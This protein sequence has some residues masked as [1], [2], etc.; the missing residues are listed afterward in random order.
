MTLLLSFPAEAKLF[1]WSSQADHSSADPHGQ[2]QLVNNAIN[3]Q[4]YETLVARG[5][6]MEIVP[7]LAERWTQA[8]ATKWTFHLRKGVKWQDGS[9][10]TADDVVFS[11]KRAQGQTSTFKVY[12][13]ALGEPRKVDAHT[14]EFTTVEPTPM[15]VEL[16]SLVAIMSKA[17]SEKHGVT[18]AQDFG[19][20][21]ET[22]ASRN[23]MGTGPFVLVSREPDVKSVFRRNPAWWGM[24][25]GLFEGNVEE[26]VYSTIKSDATRMAALASGEVDFVLDPPIQDIQKLKADKRI[27]VYEGP[28][29]LVFFLG[30]DQAREELLHADVRGR[31]PFKDRRVRLALYQAIDVEA[32]NRVVLR[33][34]AESTAI[35]HPNPEVGGIPKTLEKRYPYDLQAARKLMADAGYAKGF[36]ITMD[37]QNVRDKL[38]LAI[39]G[40]FS[41]I[42]VKAKV[43]ALQNTQFFAKGQARDTSLYLLGWGGA[44]M[45]PVFILQPVMHSKTE[46]DGDYNWGGYRDAKFDALIDR[47]KVE[48]DPAKRQAL[49]VEAMQMHHEQVFHIPLHRRKAPWAS[50]SNVEV[51]HRPNS[52]LDLAWVKVK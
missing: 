48:M 22:Y 43:N 30:M 41:Q 8:G 20:K 12:A 40:M 14:V 19:Q 25:S 17:W 37:C 5:K 34:F 35:V 11:V 51:F 6:K 9:D 2:N 31:N 16:V 1:R 42:G 29:N 39:A 24:K 3:G 49:V 18:R 36:A 38:C 33:G 15:M 26:V 32:I 13:R 28:E 4:V 47:I 52:W 21:E 10:F 50:R 27:R 45:D 46:R 44:A 23:A 7:A